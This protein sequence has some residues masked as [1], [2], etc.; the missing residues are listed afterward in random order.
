MLETTSN[1][2]LELLVCMYGYNKI[3]EVIYNRR[4]ILGQIDPG[5]INIIILFIMSVCNALSY[6][7]IYT[8]GFIIILG[9]YLITIIILTLIYKGRLTKIGIINTFSVVTSIAAYLLLPYVYNPIPVPGM[10]MV[11][12]HVARAEV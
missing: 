4:P 9:I 2:G 7:L 5:I 6:A 1:L 10:Y 3:K 12:V 8:R 11:N